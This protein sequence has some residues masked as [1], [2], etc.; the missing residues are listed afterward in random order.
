[1]TGYE[2]LREDAAWLDLSGR[3]HI[4]VT[5]EDRV[6]WLH[7][8]VSNH[9][10][11]LRPGEGCYAFLLNAQGRILADA[12]VLRQ[13]DCL[14]LD[15]EPEPRAAVLAHLDRHII[16][17]DVMLEDLSRQTAIVGLEGPRAGELLAALDGPPLERSASHAIW[18]GAL[19]A[20]LSATG[21]PGFRIFAPAEQFGELAAR[22]EKAGAV[23]AGAQEARVVRL[24][25]GRARYGEDISD[26]NLPQETQLLEALDF[27]KGCYLGQE[28]VE[29]IRSRGM[30]HRFLVFLRI[31]GTEAPVPGTAV[32]AGEKPVGEITSAAFSPA[33]GEVAALGYVRPA[34]LRGEAALTVAGRAA[35]MA[36]PRPA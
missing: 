24:E 31:A 34:E 22:L 27:N 33:L 21:A 5:G 28:I 6:R 3:G 17:D 7:A 1:M 23:R 16:A 9:V 36:G 18:G 32:L 11:R 2:A 30:V 14:L 4:R 13:D 29:R 35:R 10:E 25:Y 8:M 20:R 19:V 12:N 15:L 26:K